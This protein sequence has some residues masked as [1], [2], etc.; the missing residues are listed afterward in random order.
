MGSIIQTMTPNIPGEDGFRSTVFSAQ[1]IRAGMGVSALLVGFM[2][3]GDAGAIPCTKSY[4][5]CS[6]PAQKKPMKL[7]KSIHQENQDQ[8]S[9]IENMP[10]NWSCPH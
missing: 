7:S 4:Q 9:K 1:E 8:D 5:P 6:R 2:P 3:A 10:M